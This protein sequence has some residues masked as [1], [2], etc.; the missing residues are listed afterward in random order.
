MSADVACRSCGADAPGRRSCRSGET[1]LANALLTDEQLDQPGAD[2]FRSTSCFCPRCSLVQITETVPP[3]QLFREYLYFSSFSDTMLRHAA[4]LARAADRRARA[5]GPD[6]LVVEVAS[7]DGYLLQYYQQR[8]HPGAR[9]RAGAQHR[10]GGARGARHPHAARV[11][12]R[13]SWPQQL[14]ARGRARRRASTPT[15]CWRTWPT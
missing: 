13:A 2:A 6:S 3:E 8:G 10:A 4:T 12:R 15:T 1:P 5:L 9:H 11:L 14:A 7:N